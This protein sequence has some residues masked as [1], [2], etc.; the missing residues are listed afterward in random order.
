MR[1]SYIYI[2]C[3][4]SIIYHHTCILYAA[5][6]SSPTTFHNTQSM[7]KYQSI[8]TY[9]FLQWL[10]VT[11]MLYNSVL[12]LHEAAQLVKSLHNLVALWC[13]LFILAAETNCIIEF[14]RGSWLKDPSC[15]NTLTKVKPTLRL[16]EFKILWY[17][18]GYIPCM[19]N[20]NDQGLI[21]GR[22]V[23]RG[24]WRLERSIQQPS[25]LW[26]ISRPTCRP[27]KRS[28][29]IVLTHEPM[30]WTTAGGWR[31]LSVEPRMNS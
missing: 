14:L 20:C 28:V 8:V 9:C 1:L 23:R 18:Y 27:Q 17:M 21:P 7:Y 22:R 12:H 15:A 29:A 13:L 5:N 24:D 26:T 2:L 16:K 31:Q 6:F 25:G 19:V 11:P 10:E 3:P 4:L 30:L